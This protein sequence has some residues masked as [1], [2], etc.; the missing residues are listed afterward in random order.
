MVQNQIKS[1][2]ER[3]VGQGIPVEGIRPEIMASWERCRRRGLDPFQE[4]RWTQLQGRELKERLEASASV[5]R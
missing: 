1:C 5:V 3:F 2:W 4:V